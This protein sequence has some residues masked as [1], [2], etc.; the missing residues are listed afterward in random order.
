MVQLLTLAV[1][2]AALACGN[3]TDGSPQRL[4]A[5]RPLSAASVTG[6]GEGGVVAR[7]N[8]TGELLHWGM[9][10]RLR[11]RCPGGDPLLQ[12]ERGPVVARGTKVLALFLNHPAGDEEARQAAVVDLRK[13]RVT[14]TFSL[15]GL[16]LQGAGLDSGWALVTGP[17]PPAAGSPR[18]WVVDERGREVLTFDL[19][20][21]MSTLAEKVD[22]PPG[23]SPRGFFLVAAGKE[24]WL[25]PHARYELWRPP[26]RG[27]PLRVVN[28]PPCLTAT[29]R[30]LTG[31]EN[32]AYV[33][34]FASKLSE[35]HRSAILEGI[36]RG[37][38]KPS[39]R[40]AVTAASTYRDTLAVV[41]RS[42]ATGAGDR[43]DLWDLTSER[44]LASLPFPADVTLVSLGEGFAWV[45]DGEGRIGRWPLPEVSPADE[46]RCP[47]NAPP[48]G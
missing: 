3:A 6:D 43:L 20:E 15:P 28:P 48:P 11:H 4:E 19:E 32:V 10:G 21:A 25:L 22:L 14:A 39:F 30:I 1:A 33:T 46:F 45:R 18:V 41:V 24:L 37:G 26:Q 35:P 42:P 29:A 47:D 2:A 9:D 17:N 13:C 7:V 16:T 27:K 38:L 5:W 44:V 36:A 31:E 34:A 23:T 12:G 40:A 8:A